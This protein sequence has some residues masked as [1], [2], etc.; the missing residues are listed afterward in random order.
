M[1]A[2][3]LSAA[4][5]ALVALVGSA[6][7]PAML[8]AQPTRTAA[9]PLW[10]QGGSAFGIF[11]PS[12]RAPNATDAAGNRLPPLYTEL[13]AQALGANPLLDY[14]FLNLEGQFDMGAVK[15]M[16]AGL[17]RHPAGARP[18]LLVRIPT[19]EAAGA[20]ST[21]ARVKAIL[22]AGA[23]GVVIPHVRTAAEARLAAGFF[24]EAGANVWS[25]ANPSGTVVAMLMIEDPGAVAEM[26]AMAAIPGYS[27]L[28]CGI[29]SLTM[30][31]GGREK[32]PD[33]EAACQRVRDVAQKAGMPSM[34]TANAA[35]LRDR[36]TRGYRGLLLMGA[37]A[38]TDSLIRVGRETVG[39]R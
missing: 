12:E 37:T 28:S 22:S 17:A 21:R 35:T 10:K 38:Q 27:L 9:L 3:A 31:M 39:R 2:H 7:V 20:D 11:V 1:I 25:P 14:L 30:A 19:I 26:E 36:I 8:H 18:T 24:K 29:G 13:G 4:A 5:A 15:N 6:A 34:M 16:V 32:A 23:D 33:A